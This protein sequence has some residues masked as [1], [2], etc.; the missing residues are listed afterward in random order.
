MSYELLAMQ[1]RC[2]CFS[3]LTL[4]LNYPCMWGY[5]CGHEMSHTRL[6]RFQEGDAFLRSGPRL[7][8][9]PPDLGFPTL[10]VGHRTRRCGHVE[11]KVYVEDWEDDILDNISLANLIQDFINVRWTFH[12]LDLI[13]VIVWNDVACCRHILFLPRSNIVGQEAQFRIC[14]WMPESTR[15]QPVL[16]TN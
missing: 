15:R 6:G 5:I 1:E 9:W 7:G 14:P 13:K 3:A 4:P 11:N 16:I 8:W 12:L 2:K 10:F